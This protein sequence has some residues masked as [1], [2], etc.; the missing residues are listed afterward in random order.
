VPV[1]RLVVMRSTAKDEVIAAIAFLTWPALFAPVIAPVLG[2]VLTT[3]ASWR[4]IFLI[5]VPLG[6]VGLVLAI[7]LVPNLRSATPKRLDWIGLITS[8]LG[9]GAFVY[10]VSLVDGR[11]VPVLAVTGF[12]VA[13]A[14]LLTVAVWH[15]WRTPVPLVDLRPLMIT[16]FRASQVGGSLY[17]TSILAVPFLLPLMFQDDFGWSAAKAGSFVIFV[18]VGNLCIKPATTPLLRRFGFRF[19]L[20]A[21]IVVGALATAGCGLLRSDTPLAVIAVLL[22][23]GGAFRSI[24]FTAYNTIA[25]ADVDQTNVVH[26]NTLSSTLQ[27]L[28][29]GLAIAAGAL[30]LRLGQALRAPLGHPHSTDITYTVAFF[31]VAALLIGSFVEVWRLPR[32][33]G[34]LIG[35]GAGKRGT[36][37]RKVS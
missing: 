19:V 15:L 22:V 31:A 18:F 32:S 25:F 24:G 6:V 14:V 20:L 29:S 27:Q 33:A 10:G 37:I 5:N 2:G 1:G 30:G 11:N 23:I 26:A 16:T 35:G 8:T 13:A 9:L 4:W 3:Y 12:L 17:R 7:R 28:A 36:N 21:S 34:V